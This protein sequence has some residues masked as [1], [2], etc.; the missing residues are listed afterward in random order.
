MLSMLVWTEAM[1][2]FKMTSSPSC[3]R[4]CRC[5]KIKRSVKWRVAS[6]NRQYIHMCV[7][8]LVAYQQAAVQLCR[9]QGSHFTTAL[10]ENATLTTV[11][12]TSQ[13]YQILPMNCFAKRLIS[14]VGQSLRGL[15]TL[16]AVSRSI[17]Y[18]LLDVESARTNDD[19]RISGMDTER[20][21]LLHVA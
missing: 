10:S 4:G 20:I 15:A 2:R 5:E 6:C 9:R 8:I 12:S 18:S 13:D 21:N 3:L 16:M 11:R 1:L 7:R 17:W 19:N 14:V